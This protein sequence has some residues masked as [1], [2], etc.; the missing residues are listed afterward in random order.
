MSR[1]N[2]ILLCKEHLFT[3]AD[4][5]R[6]KVPEAEYHKILRCRVMYLWMVEHPQSK[7]A[8]FVSTDC[9]RFKVSRPTAY[10][11]L[12]VI[13][14]ILPDLSATSRAFN[15][16]K[17]NQM[18]L[19]TY[20]AARKKGDTRTMEKAAR[21]FAQ[22]NKV[23]SDREEI[24]LSDLQ[25]QPFVPTMDPRVLGIE[26]LPNLRERKRKLLERMIAEVEDVRDIDFEPADVAEIRERPLQLPK[27]GTTSGIL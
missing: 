5:L 11:D 10:S 13:K 24:D 2:T 15:L 26:P 8:E 6:G 1:N 25:P 18:L 20:E 22:I 4:E 9:D 27:D 7:D 23:D 12:N 16:W 14:A 17:S 19:D 3:D 21:T